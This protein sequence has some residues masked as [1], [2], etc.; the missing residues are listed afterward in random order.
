MSTILREA[1]GE[2]IEE[3]NYGFLGRILRPGNGVRL[4]FINKL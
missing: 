4:H 3:I 2:L 1:L